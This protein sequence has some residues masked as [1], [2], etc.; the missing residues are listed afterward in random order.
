MASGGNVAVAMPGDAMLVRAPRRARGRLR[1]VF[2]GV[3]ALVASR[4]PSPS[5]V[6][7]LSVAPGG[8][9]FAPR[10]DAPDLA[11]HPRRPGLPDKSAQVAHYQAMAEHAA[12]ERAMADLDRRHRAL[13][14]RADVSR[15]LWL[16]GAA[17]MQGERRD[18]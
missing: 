17:H 3:G 7:R 2:H 14:D 13:A 5:T 12:R 10:R 11:V 8:G 16:A 1:S 6:P 18:G 15:D 4:R 9:W